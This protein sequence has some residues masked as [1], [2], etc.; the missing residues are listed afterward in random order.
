MVS[1]R[2]T[3]LCIC[4]AVLRGALVAAYEVDAQGAAGTDRRSLFIPY[5]ITT[6][7]DNE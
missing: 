2:C 6:E 3:G 1:R 7:S 4:N 5:F